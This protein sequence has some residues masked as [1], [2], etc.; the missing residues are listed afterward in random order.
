MASKINPKDKKMTIT[1]EQLQEYSNT[2]EG[3][4]LFSELMK[5]QAKELGY[6][7]P[8]EVQGL[9]NKRNELLDKVKALKNEKN[10]DPLLT[11]LQKHGIYDVN[12]L[13]SLLS[14]SPSGKKS[15][16]IESKLKQFEREL[17]QERKAKLELESSL[18]KQRERFHNAEKQSAILKALGAAGIDESAHDILSVYF[19]RIAKVEED[20]TGKLNILA[21]DGEQSLGLHDYISKWSQTD[22]AKNYK[23]APVNSGAGTSTGGK[24]SP[25]MTME[26]IALLPPAEMVKALKENGL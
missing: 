10:S 2:D 21:D 22:K 13:E 6:V 12:D 25:K 11:N 24:L 9:I 18:N 16:E 1:K 5:A 7:T 23:K 19:D 8:D 15:D 3:K 17:G 20:D 26:E 14:T 4:Q